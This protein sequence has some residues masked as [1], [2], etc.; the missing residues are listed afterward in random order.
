M[1]L[2]VDFTETNTVMDVSFG[3]AYG[4]GGGG[5]IT[6]EV[7]PT[8]PEWAKQPEKPTY[9]AEEVGALPSDTPLVKDEDVVHKEGFEEI[10][11][12]KQFHD[13][14]DTPKIS[15]DGN[16][17][18]FNSYGASLKL[19]D[20]G[21][22]LAN[23]KE[24]ATKLETKNYVDEQTEIIKTDV[25]GLQKQLNEEAHFRGYLS[26]NAKI[27]ALE[28][29]PN[30]FAYSAESGTKWV[31][32]AENGWQDTSTPVPDQL[33]PASNATPLVN[34]EA[35][36]GQSEEYARGDHRHPTDTTRVSVEAFNEFKSSLE[37]AFD[38]IIAIQNSLIGGGS[39]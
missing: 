25:E 9:T 33:T 38:S 14:I 12:V 17:E 15:Y 31:Y 27:Q 26:T 30:D 39:V 8:V 35:S 11:G 5:G 23:G 36:A 3:E 34:G 21:N 32:D 18:F 16:L 10:N 22:V 19:D 37:T 24:V 20:E 2:D 1:I 4:E 13:G 6:E 28:A 7:D 29:T